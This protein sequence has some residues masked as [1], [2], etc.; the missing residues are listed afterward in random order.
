MPNFHP[1]VSAKASS[2]AKR[3]TPLAFVQNPLAARQSFQ[4]PLS[5]DV[6]QA[7]NPWS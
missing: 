1:R 4:M 3:S 2:E 5:G 7:I 6:M